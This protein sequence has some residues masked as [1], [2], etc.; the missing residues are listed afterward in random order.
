MP[1]TELP[2]D[3]TRT[4][5]DIARTFLDDESVDETLDRIVNLSVE[6]VES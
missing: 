3:L 5:S 4:F 6:S 1:K 2:T